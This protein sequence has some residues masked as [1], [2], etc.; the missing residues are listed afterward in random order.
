MSVFFFLET[1]RFCFGKIR[2]LESEVTQDSTS[3]CACTHTHTHTYTHT[4][5][6][7]RA[8]ANTMHELRQDTFV[9]KEMYTCEKRS[10]VQTYKCQER[11]IKEIYVC[12]K[13]LIK[14][15]Y[16]RGKRPTKETYLCER[17]LHER[18]TR[19]KRDVRV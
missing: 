4:H 1:S 2:L 15:T 18:H 14:G 13:R 12:G 3:G 10:I 17:N 7:T 16:M 19:V 11:P 9:S 5:A 8:R 6:H